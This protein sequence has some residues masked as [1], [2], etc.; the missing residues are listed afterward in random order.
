MQARFA[1]T[2]II[3]YVLQPISAF[4]SVKRWTQRLSDKKHYI[5]REALAEKSR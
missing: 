4:G 5:R 3:A 2:K 1:L